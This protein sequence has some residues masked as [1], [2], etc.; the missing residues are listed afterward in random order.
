MPLN[1]KSNIGLNHSDM[2]DLSVP[3][4]FQDR[5]HTCF[6]NPTSLK[7]QNVSH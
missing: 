4:A 6:Q 7:V 5:G 3:I 1:V 2:L